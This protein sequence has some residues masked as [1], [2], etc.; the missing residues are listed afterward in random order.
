MAY[1]ISQKQ[2]I[3]LLRKKCIMDIFTKVKCI[4]WRFLKNNDFQITLK[5]NHAW[6][7]LQLHSHILIQLFKNN[8]K[9]SRDYLILLS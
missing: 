1:Y 8:K 6:H 4:N 3:A 5:K 7:H 9:L 2:L